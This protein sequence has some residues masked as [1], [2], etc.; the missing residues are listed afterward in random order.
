M[1]QN[2]APTH[3]IEPTIEG[4]MYLIELYQQVLDERD[5]LLAEV[6][7]LSAIL[8]RTQVRL[9]D[10][11]LRA[12]ELEGHVQSLEQGKRALMGQNQ[13]MAS[14]LTTAQIRRLEAEKLLLETRVSWHRERQNGAASSDAGGP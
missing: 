11:S 1:I 5:A 4:K 7:D 10:T 9:E 14:R 3:G 8:E 12:T 13:D 2:P 6:Q